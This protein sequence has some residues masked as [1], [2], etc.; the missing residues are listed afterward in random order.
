MFNT[1][2]LIG[3]NPPLSPLGEQYS[4]VLV[5]FVE[6]SD[7]LSTDEVRSNGRPGRVYPVLGIFEKSYSWVPKHLGISIVLEPNFV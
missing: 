7:E 4:K 1:K 5:D 3:G 2:G 6:Q